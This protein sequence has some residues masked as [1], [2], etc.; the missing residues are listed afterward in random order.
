MMTKRQQERAPTLVDDADISENR[1]FAWNLIRM[2]K[3]NE[4]SFEV[5]LPRP[6]ERWH[7]AHAR[8]KHNKG[9]FQHG[10]RS[11]VS[12][13]GAVWVKLAQIKGMSYDKAFGEDEVMEMN[14]LREANQ[15]G[16]ET[17]VE[18]GLDEEDTEDLQIV[19]LDG[20]EDDTPWEGKEESWH[21]TE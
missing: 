18:L 21:E 4:D 20:E 7:R 9:S 3:K 1:A 16:E 6:N 8:G 5:D 10:G 2:A 14:A 12:K 17:G 15:R 11:H 13:Y 19:R